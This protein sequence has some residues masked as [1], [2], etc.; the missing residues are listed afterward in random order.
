[1]KQYSNYAF[2]LGIWG[3]KIKLIVVQRTK[4]RRKQFV[5]GH[6]I[7]KVGNIIFAYGNISCFITVKFYYWLLLFG[8]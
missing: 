3:G 2:I 6:G 7:C 4:R 5:I 8:V 1:M